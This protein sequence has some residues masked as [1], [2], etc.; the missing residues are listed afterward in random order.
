MTKRQKRANLVAILIGVVVTAGVVAAY[1]FGGLDRI[2]RMTL[3]QRFRHTN[4][5]HEYPS[6]EDPA[7][8][9]ID[10]DDTSLEVLGRWPWTRDRQAP[11]VAIPA[12]LGARA[13]LAD[14]T[15]TE[16]EDPRLDRGDNADIASD[17]LELT[18]TGSADGLPGKIVFPDYELATAIRDAGN[19]YLAYDY[20]TD[21]LED[22]DAFNAEVDALLAA[23]GDISAAGGDASLRVR[24]VAALQREPALTADELAKRLAV[25]DASQLAT[26]LDRSRIAALRR[27]LWKWLDEQPERWEQSLF[28]LYV[29]FHVELTGLPPTGKT[30]LTAA[31]NVALRD[32][33]GWRATTAGDAFD[34]DA[35]RSAAPPVQGI[36]PVYYLHARAAKR[37]GFV[38][39]APDSDGVVRLMPLR[40]R[41]RGRV[42]PQLAFVLACDELGVPP[43]GASVN[44]RTLTLKTPSGP[45]A[46]L[47]IQLDDGGRT[48]I[49]WVKGRDW[50][51]V[52][53][54]LPAD[55]IMALHDHRQDIQRNNEIVLEALWEILALDAL[56]PLAD[57]QKTIEGVFDL[58]GQ[59][60]IS[61]Y[62]NSEGDVRE[63][64][65]IRDSLLAET[66]EIERQVR[67][68]A[69]TIMGE[70]TSNDEQ[71]QRLQSL[72]GTIDECH[73][74]EPEL[75]KTVEQ[76]AA[77]IRGIVDGKICL[78]G[79]TA[80]SLA[81][82]KPIPTSPSAAG[83]MA[84]ANMLNGLLSG[85]LMRWASTPLNAA[86]AAAF[87][88]LTT[89]LATFMRAR[90]ALVFTV[91]LAVSYVAVAG[92]LVFHQYAY[93]LAVTPVASA[94][95]I[96]YVCISAYRYVFIEGERRQLA[97]ALGQYTS[98]E[99]ARQM[100]EN[101]ELCRR[102][103]MREVTA[104][105]TD[106]K[107]F[108][109]IS[110]RIGAERTQKVL[111]IC[112]GRFTEIMLKHEGM[113]NKFIG[114]GIFAF[115][116]P[117]IYPQADHARRACE[118]AIDLQSGLEDLKKEQSKRGG[119]EVFDEIILR[120]GIAT[121]NAIVGPCGSK[122][123]FDY[124]C[125]GDSVNVAARLESA[126]K[127]YGT[128]LLISAATRD[129]A[130]D[131]F[132]WRA[133]GG[134]QVKG[135]RHAVPVYELLG[136]AGHVPADLLAY[137]SEFGAAVTRFQQRDWEGARDGFEA[138]RRRRPDD[139]A[140]AEYI[141]A[142]KALL[143]DPP[144]ADW[145]GAIELKEK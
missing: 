105:F 139:S 45:Q 129:G 145:L 110:E 38:V 127:F 37:C 55:A 113:V 42:L 27:R 25:D 32:V 133:L 88:L 49:P 47:S 35:V 76:L 10:I 94:I 141:E 117:V 98:K 33:L 75:Q 46:S 40:R 64:S 13:I 119:D 65:A 57:H 91:F 58:D 93:F 48:M 135:K 131:G 90:L 144:G 73:R 3:D 68:R 63:L 12:E 82:M 85:Q 51:R 11:L 28:E 92:M 8:V 125:I 96:T 124:T 104:V 69:Q 15:W 84:H 81:D 86:I 7:I 21:D 114:D 60:R 100:A 43:D 66:S 62:R 101:P 111:N 137:A 108:T 41:H 109:S 116:N 39:F 1:L 53:R 80:T 87:G 140:A 61:R 77:R 78:I 89:L 18:N 136:R 143:S 2:E 14:L 123:K 44:G 52:F 70:S 54:H 67:E 29:P 19:A 138:C 134:V 95:L 130:G 5:I 72:L 122:Q 79:Y 74:V 112:L 30:P 50:T 115:W 106:L 128:R 4:S 31:E 142:T 9:C 107:G 126:N 83:V 118:T 16:A 99:M 22:S 103:E 6:H 24:M 59:I 120:I 23:G 56:A 20:S 71:L 34:L 26:W 121:G 97:T 17:P 132:E 36:T 102:A